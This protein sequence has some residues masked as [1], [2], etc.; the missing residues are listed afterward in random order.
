[1]S[2]YHSGNNE[3]FICVNYSIQITKIPIIYFRESVYYR[4]I[5]LKKYILCCAFVQQTLICSKNK[6]KVQEVIAKEASCSERAEKLSAKKTKGKPKNMNWNNRILWSRRN[7]CSGF[8]G[9]R[10]TWC[11]PQ[12]QSELQTK[13]APIPKQKTSWAEEK[14]LDC[15]SVICK[16]MCN[17]CSFFTND[18]PSCRVVLE[19]TSLCFLYVPFKVALLP[20]ASTFFSNNFAFHSTFQLHYVL[21]QSQLSLQ[22]PLDLNY[23]WNAVMSSSWL[24]A[25]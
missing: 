21:R 9:G 19:T 18:H 24:N 15:C 16:Y 14:R 23:S 25:A 5:N 4:N 10:F 8:F 3:D 13:S 11:G 22:W 7:A 17:I 2:N 1:M 20:L 6:V 12:L